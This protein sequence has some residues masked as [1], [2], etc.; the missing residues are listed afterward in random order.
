MKRLKAEVEMGRFENEMKLT[1]RRIPVEKLVQMYTDWPS[2]SK[3]GKKPLIVSVSW[4]GMPKDPIEVSKRYQFGNLNM[5]IHSTRDR[6][7]NGLQTVE[8]NF[9]GKNCLKGTVCSLVESFF[10]K[11]LQPSE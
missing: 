9:S 8:L 5:I 1:F 10:V 3:F 6:F 2:Y 11:Y 4:A 7:D